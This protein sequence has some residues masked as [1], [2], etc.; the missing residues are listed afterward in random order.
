MFLL[1]MT[2]HVIELTATPQIGDE[3]TIIIV[4]LH[5]FCENKVATKQICKAEGKDLVNSPWISKDAIGDVTVS[6]KK[7]DEGVRL[8]I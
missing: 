4:L 5:F 6:L 8:E 1:L 3:E 7:Q 2:F